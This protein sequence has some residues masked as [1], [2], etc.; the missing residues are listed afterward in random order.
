MLNALWSLLLLLG[1]GYGLITGQAA[2]VTAAI[3]DGA[4][5]AIEL[6]LTMFGIIALWSG[7][8]EI[9]E[10][11]GLV[12][13]LAKKM[14]PLLHF[15]FPRIPD[16][17]PSLRYIA[18]NFVANILGLGWAATPAGLKA[19]ESLAGLEQS[20]RTETQVE[21]I[22]TNSDRKQ[23]Q[24]ALGETKNAQSRRKKPYAMPN[25]TASNEMCTFLILNVSSLQLIPVNMIA[26]RAQYGS[27]NPAAIVGPG[28]LATAVSTL[29][30]VLFCKLMDSLVKN[31]GK[32]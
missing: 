8:M 2:A 7:V 15:L 6:C 28:I 30:A 14:K 1:I 4:S 22:D 10:R 27:Q 18:V 12:E 24:K 32:C 16:S 31:K 21:M 9:G 3:L 25:G 13:K 26:Y 17:H 20:R 11:A 19:M 5:D 29:T 23:A